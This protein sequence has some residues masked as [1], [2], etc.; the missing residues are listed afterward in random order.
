MRQQVPTHT[1]NTEQ[2]PC[3]TGR[4]IF[5]EKRDFGFFAK[6]GFSGVLFFAFNHGVHLFEPENKRLQHC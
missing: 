4:R 1:L 6:N 2:S 3:P 5:T